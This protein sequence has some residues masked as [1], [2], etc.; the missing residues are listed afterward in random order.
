MVADFR[1]RF[2][3]SLAL[4]VPI[5]AISEHFWALVGLRP[6]V[7]FTGDRYAL[8]TFA[9]VVYFY[10]GWPFLK[11]AGGEIAERKPG[12]MLLVAVAISAAFFYSAAVTFGLT[13]AGFYWELATLVD[14]MLLGHW[15]EMRSVM[16]ASSA[17]EALVRLLPAEA[18]RLKADGST[19]EVTIDRLVPGDRVLVKPA[20]RVPTDGVIVAGITSLNESMLTG[21][22]KPVEK[23]EGGAVIGG[24]VNGDG[25]ITVEIR[26]TGGDTYLAQVMEMVR[27]AQESRS[28]SQ[29]LANRAAVW[30]TAIALGVGAATFIVWLAIA[31]DAEFALARAVTVMVIACPHAL[32]LAVPLVVAVSTSLSA[33]H[34]LLI[35][36]R[37]AFERA[38]NLQAVV[39]DK[40]GTLTEGRYGV[41]DIVALGELSEEECLRIAAALESQSEHPIA[42]GV[43]GAAA[44]RNLKLPSVSG[45]KNLTGRGAQARVDGR[46][47]LVVSPGY[48]REKDLAPDDA[49]IATLAE[50]GK[51]LVYLVVDGKLASAIALADVVRPESRA[52]VDELKRLGIQ[53][54]M[55]TGDSR[56]VAKAVAAEL[57]LDHFFAEVLPEEKAAKIKE[58]QR[59]GLA[60]AMVGD[61]VNDAPALTQSDLGIAIGAG[62]D[63]AIE[64]ADIV[65]VRSDPRDV[66]AIVGLARRTY[67]KIVQNLAWATGYNAFAIPLAAGVATAWG[68]V[69]TP[70]FGAVLMSV[71]TVIVAINARLLGKPPA[72][73]G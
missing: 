30:L 7:S 65:L 8:F 4:T 32:G 52:A 11:G 69:L 47:A 28:R 70:A 35:R 17:L 45:F 16:G 27:R 61:G 22:S 15:I 53:C 34:G 23:G 19:E 68:I 38:R 58:V 18:H 48:L 46:E 25:A 67:G 57:G 60:V 29:D 71:S 24:S 56:A 31:G 73:R 40:T 51:T 21:E 36:D 13:G 3:V 26:K 2:W 72:R 33:S 42:K 54:M 59:R 43:T 39:F 37:A 5:L 6:V 10:G 66:A 50:Q 55:L 44:E 14:V 41:S 9:A 1:R 20:E 62:T 64:S 49:R 63:V 12:M